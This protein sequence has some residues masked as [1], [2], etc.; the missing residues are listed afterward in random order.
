MF[1]RTLFTALI[2]VLAGCDAGVDPSSHSQDVSMMDS[3]K[4][5]KL[6]ACETKDTVRVK[7]CHVSIPDHLTCN[8]KQCTED[9]YTP[10]PS[11]KFWAAIDT[12]YPS[13]NYSVMNPVDRESLAYALKKKQDSH[14]SANEIKQFTAWLANFD[15]KLE[16]K[17]MLA[18]NVTSEAYLDTHDIYK[19]IAKP[20]IDVQAEEAV[21]AAHTAEVDPEKAKLDAEYGEAYLK[22]AMAMYECRDRCL[23]NS[24]CRLD[25][26]RYYTP[27]WTLDCQAKAHRRI[28]GYDRN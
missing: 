3:Q 10:M 16:L 26:L 22:C 6:V 15:K 19:T 27:E 2:L 9:Y 7:V 17:N 18:K 12:R 23:W 20:F 28:F 5:V 13:S 8:S 11:S 21:A 1:R 4:N 24:S 25:C 14:A